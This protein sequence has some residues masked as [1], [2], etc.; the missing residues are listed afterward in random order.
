MHKGVRRDK[1]IKMK[2]TKQS[3]QEKLF[4]LEENLSQKQSRV[5]R[6]Q[7]DLNQSLRLYEKAQERYANA[8]YKMQQVEAVV[9]H[10]KKTNRTIESNEL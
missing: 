1:G 6:T 10:V 3:L 5:K 7:S 8:C 4:R 9:N 2:Q